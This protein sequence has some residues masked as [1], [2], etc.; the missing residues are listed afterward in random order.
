MPMHFTG[1]KCVWNTQKMQDVCI[2]GCSTQKVQ[3]CFSVQ[4]VLFRW[5]RCFLG[6]TG[7]FW[8]NTCT[9]YNRCFLVHLVHQIQ[10]VIFWCHRCT[11]Y[12]GCVFV[13]IGAL[14]TT[15]MFFVQ[16]VHQLQWVFL[17]QQVHQIQWVC[18]WCNRSTKYNGCYF[19]CNWCTKYNGWF[20]M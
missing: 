2:W 20:L 17:L 18:F 16:W 7:N 8:C 3:R 10:W 19:W 12:N 15:S 1:A 6:T 11:K 5:N 9:N 14:N 4:L 13:A